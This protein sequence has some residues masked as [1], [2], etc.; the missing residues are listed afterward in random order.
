MIFAQTWNTL[1]SAQYSN[2]P[3]Y[4]ASA[5][6]EVTGNIYVAY[7]DQTDNDHLKVKYFDGTNWLDLGPTVSA[8]GNVLYPSVRM[9]PATNEIWVAYRT[10]IGGNQMLNVRRYNGTSWIDEGTDIAGEDFFNNPYVPDEKIILRFSPAGDAYIAFQIATQQSSWVTTNRTGSWVNE[11]GGSHIPYGL[12]FPAYNL[13]YYSYEGGFPTETVLQRRTLNTSTNNWNAPQIIYNNGLPATNYQGL[14]V[15]TGSVQA[16]LHDFNSVQDIDMLTWNSLLPSPAN[17]DLCDGKSLQI[18]RNPVDGLTYLLYVKTTGQV[19]L[20]TFDGGAWT[21]ISSLSVNVGTTSNNTNALLAK[22]NIRD[23]DGRVFVTHKDGTSITTQYMDVTPAPTKVFVDLDATGN[24]DGTSWADAFTDLQDGIV[25]AEN[26][27]IADTVWV[28]EGTY[29]P[30]SGTDR[31]QRFDIT[32]NG[33]KIFGGFNGT[34]TSFGQ[35]DVQ[36]NPTII[37]GDLSDNDNPND[38]TYTSLF[39]ADNSYKLFYVDADN[40][41]INGFTLKGGQANNTNNNF[42]NRGAAVY[43]E[44]DAANFSIVHCIVTENVAN[45]EGTLHLPFNINSTLTIESCEFSNNFG[46]YGAGFAANHTSSSTSLTALVNNCLFHNNVSG[47]VATGDGFTASSFGFFLNNGGTINVTITNNTFTQNFDLG[48]NGSDKGTVVLRRFASGDVLNVEMHNNIFWDNFI[49][50]SGG[51]NP[52][53]IGLMN[54]NLPI[55]TLNFTHNNSN[56]TNLSSKA[57]NLTEANTT[58]LDPLFVDELNL[59]FQLQS[60]SP[61]I[62]AGDNT[63]VPCGITEDI[64]GNNRFENTTVDRGAYEFFVPNAVPPTAVTQ[65]ITVQLDANGQA[66][67]QPSDIDNGSTD[68]ETPQQD[69]ILSLDIS[70]FGCSDIGANTVTLTVE[71]DAGNTATG[72]ATVTVEDVTVP[73]VVTQNI[74]VQLD[75]NGQ[76][77]IQPSDVNNGSSDN[78]SI[79]NY[80]LDVSSFNCSNIGTNTV[81]LTATDPSGNSATANATV[82]VQDITAP[83]VATQNITVQ[84]DVN[85][86]ATITTSDINNGSSDNCVVDQLSLDITSFTC[87]DLGANT[88]TLTVQDASGNS[89]SGTAT[90]TVVDNINPVVLTQNA[91][92]VLDANGQGS[93]LTQDIDNGSTDNC[94][95]NTTSLDITS[96]DCSDIGPNTVTL[97]VEDA[98][99]NTASATATVNVIDNI[100]PNVVTQNITVTLDANGNATISANDIDNGTTDNCAVANTYLD[101]TSFDCSNIGANTV[102]LFAEDGESNT[103]TGTATVTV[104]ETT[105]PVAVTQNLTVTLDANGQATITPGDIDNGSTDNCSVDQLSIDVTSFTCSDLGS[106]LVTLT[107]EDASGNTSSETATV[108]VV[109]NI[110]PVANVNTL[111]TLSLDANGQATLSGSDVDNGSSDNC[112]VASTT[113]DITSFDCTDIGTTQTVNF[114]VTDDSGNTA[115]T[116]ANVEIID[117]LAPNVITQPV[118]VTLDA[119]GEASITAQD[120]DNGSTDNCGI[121][122]L[123]I[124]ITDFTCTDIGT[125]T[126]TLTVEDNYGNIG[127]ATAIVTVTENI[128]PVAVTQDITIALD[129]N[130]EA[131]IVSSDIDNGSTDNCGIDALDLDLTDFTCG[132]LGANSVT[133]TVTD[134][135]GNTDTETA[136]VTVEDNIAPDV[137]GQDITVQL[138]GGQV[139]IVAAD[140]DNGSTDNCGV[141]NLSIDQDTFTAAGVYPVVLTVTDASGNSATTTV[142]VTVEDVASLGETTKTSLTVAPNPTSATVNI[143]SNL[144]IDNI[145]IYD[146]Y[147][148]LIGNSTTNVIDMTEY[149]NGVYTLYILQKNG[150]SATRKIV[151][152]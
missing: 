51:V 35:R 108:T 33:V 2:N 41:E 89:S 126:V 81:Q 101:I 74:T 50:N 27:S 48:T 90:V 61:M 130:G 93:I 21:E 31:N 135:S 152:Q 120:V 146:S 52:Q 138:S 39:R 103:A 149:A 143:I 133:L 64:L 119:N 4:M 109:D 70:S 8:I 131:S 29:K 3:L 53:V 85:G 106:N 47:D 20:S 91:T 58:N 45:R 57:S 79:D 59:D 139:T 88:V 113:V 127:T 122:S 134:A 82:T 30:T 38:V 15:T 76:A 141:D 56:Q 98:S 99:G 94:A 105:A 100:A 150:H 16:V 114:T 67:I 43:K 10:D 112:S 42:S 17:S 97:T 140:V 36:S 9:N 117:D 73:T 145:L 6:D 19:V 66:T 87:T 5:I 129:A 104:V 71:D 55:T 75:V 28:A 24:N 136:T 26:S 96:F 62:D 144:D 49:D 25:A 44:A 18:Q 116:S 37:S 40:I 148:R 92:V 46:R 115:S 14:A 84:L 32:G 118:T 78:C 80:S 13:F 142:E 60:S 137:V 110:N 72:T 1:G 121:A 77:T 65:G 102:T 95:V 86:D 22:L 147:G 111:T 11:I 69:L 125:N 123:S 124:D 68:D 63:Q 54:A 83:T 34:E 107:V 23:S 12:D 128:S 132:E 7:V 151:K